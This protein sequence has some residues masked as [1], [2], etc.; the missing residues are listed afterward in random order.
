MKNA[1]LH[2]NHL[3]I[4]YMHQPL[5]FRDPHHLDHVCLLKK[6]LYGLKQAPR[7]QYQQ[8]ADYVRT[9]GFFS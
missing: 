5:G 9:L 7:E 1:S 3:E 6:A 4:L 8:F 2:R